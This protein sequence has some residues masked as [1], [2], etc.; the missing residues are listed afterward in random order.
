LA[1]ATQ[2]AEQQQGL[3]GRTLSSSLGSGIDSSLN[4]VIDS[5]ASIADGT[6]SAG[7]GFRGLAVSVASS[8]A[9]ILRQLALAIAKQLIF[10]A[11]ANSGNPYLMAAGAALGGTKARV[12]HSGGVVGS[13]NGRSRVVNPGWFANAPRFHE[14]GL[15]GLRSDEV[16]SILQTGEEVLSR[17]DPRNV[18][19]GASRTAGANSAGTRFVL[20][21]DRSKIPE[22]MQSAEGE[23]VIV[24]TIRRNSPTIKQMLK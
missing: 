22:A 1:V 17:D 11:L 5:L 10:N 24:Q 3:L 12:N 13:P 4:A 20:V 14:G 18:M 9:D 8:V 23:N 2:N 7:E 21:D 15:P 6:K 16:P 19:N